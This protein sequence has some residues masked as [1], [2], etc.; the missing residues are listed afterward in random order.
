MT[1]NMIDIM[2]YDVMQCDIESLCED[3]AD[4]PRSMFQKIEEDGLEKFAKGP[5]KT[6]VYY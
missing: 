4:K 1:N 6:S 5:K 3:N 2:Q